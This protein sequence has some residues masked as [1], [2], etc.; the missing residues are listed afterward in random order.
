MDNTETKNSTAAIEKSNSK[1][2]VVSLAASPSPAGRPRVTPSGCSGD[3]A[4][5]HSHADKKSGSFN[6]E[7]RDVVTDYHSMIWSKG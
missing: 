7:C 6:C 1:S 4:D 5:H 2:H 3:P